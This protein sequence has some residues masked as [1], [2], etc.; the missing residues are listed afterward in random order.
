MVAALMIADILKNN[1]ASKNK[2]IPKTVNEQTPNKN[3]FFKETS[4]QTIWLV[5]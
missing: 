2:V 3:D 4:F 5:L 1:D